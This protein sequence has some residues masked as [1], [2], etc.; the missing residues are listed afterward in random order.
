MS[1]NELNKKNDYDTL[2][3]NYFSKKKNDI[4]HSQL[5]KYRMMKLN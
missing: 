2:E 1:P 4:A 5:T 3:K